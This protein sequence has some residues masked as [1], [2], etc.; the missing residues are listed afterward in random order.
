MTK[1]KYLKKNGVYYGFEETGHSGFAESGEDIL[2]AA[3][4]AMTMLIINS[5]EVVYGSD[6]DY[7]IDEETADI[8]VVAMDALPETGADEKK[9]YAVAGLI[10]SY[11]LQLMDMT[12]EYYD[13]LEVTEQAE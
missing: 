3:I 2:C 11:Y 4:S 12:E 6:V 1:I 8:K 10:Y 5:I 13:Y 9:R 7:T